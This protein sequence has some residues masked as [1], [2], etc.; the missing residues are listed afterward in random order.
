MFYILVRRAPLGQ[1]LPVRASSS[2]DAVTVP[3]PGTEIRVL[4][5]E[6]NLVNQQLLR[7]QLVRSGCIVHVANHGAEALE[8]LNTLSKEIDVI[9][10]DTQMPVMNGLECTRRIRQLEEE[11]GAKKRTPIIAVTANERKEQVDEALENG[12]VS[13]PRSLSL[14]PSAKGWS[15]NCLIG[16]C[17]AEAVQD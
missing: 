6:D 9:L 13:F 2:T 10:M 14:V 4:L 15:T 8:M 11:D 7:K 17:D 16:C 1:V 5:V 3:T 12:A